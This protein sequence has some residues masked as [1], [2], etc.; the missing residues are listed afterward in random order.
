MTTPVVESLM[1]IHEQNF[2]VACER[3]KKY[4]KKY[5]AKYD[6]KHK[7]KPFNLKKGDHVQVKK[8]RTKKAKG[9][10]TELKWSPRNSFYKLFKIDKNQ[11]TVQV[12][13]KNGQVLKKHFNM[14]NVRLFRGD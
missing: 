5:K 6:K 1:N 7:T 3:I 14:D 9:G 8:I 10:K 4:R 11:K 2:G 12:K 13:G